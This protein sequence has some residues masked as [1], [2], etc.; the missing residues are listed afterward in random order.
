MNRTVDAFTLTQEG[1]GSWA[2]SCGEWLSSYG[3]VEVSQRVVAYLY[4]PVRGVQSRYV[5]RVD[6]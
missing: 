2:R 6:R 3:Q 5:G 4:D 1:C